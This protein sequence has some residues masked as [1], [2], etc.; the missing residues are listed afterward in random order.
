MFSN[1]ELGICEKGS[2]GC[3]SH[4]S[5]PCEICGRYAAGLL[6]AP[7]ENRGVIRVLSEATHNAS[8][9]DIVEKSIEHGWTEKQLLI[10]I[11]M[12]F[13]HE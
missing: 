9:V 8:T 11:C 1:R 4:L 2:P 7:D 3:A 10:A 13:L 12:R 6:N 5:H